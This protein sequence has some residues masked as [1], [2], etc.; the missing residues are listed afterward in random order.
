MMIRSKR[1][2]LWALLMWSTF[3]PVAGTMS[4]LWIIKT[5]Q[6]VPMS[7]RLSTVW[8]PVPLYWPRLVPPWSQS[9]TPSAWSASCSVHAWSLWSL[10]TCLFVC[11]QPLPGFHSTVGARDISLAFITRAWHTVFSK[12]KAGHQIHQIPWCFSNTPY[13]IVVLSSP[14]TPLEPQAVI[15]S[16][17]RTGRL[18]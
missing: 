18:S 4:S 8:T 3:Q 13:G 17:H 10:L 9:S 1:Y 12:K 16:Q 15:S 5:T 6:T 2:L 7:S 11:F 14:S